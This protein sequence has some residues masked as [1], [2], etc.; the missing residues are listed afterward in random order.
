ME[1]KRILLPTDYSETSREALRYAAGMAEKFRAELVVLN[2][3]NEQL[4]TEGLNIPLAI[5]M[6]TL[7]EDMQ[8][9]ATKQMERFLSSGEVDDSVSTRRVILQG[10]PWE[11]ITRWAGENQVDLIVIGTHG[12]SGIEHFLFG[13]TAEKVI[14]SAPCPVLTVRPP[15]AGE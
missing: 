6:E 12:R 15:A 8:Q 11:V 4:F 14:R 9:E 1:L 2:V 3:V 10:K 5:S 7:E 13:S